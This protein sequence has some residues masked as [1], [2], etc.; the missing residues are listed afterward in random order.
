MSLYI[1]E[2]A[3]RTYAVTTGSG[4]AL[5]AKIAL[6]YE[7][8]SP[9]LRITVKTHK[10]T[11][12]SV[13][14]DL[15]YGPISVKKPN[16][17][18][19]TFAQGGVYTL[20]YDGQAFI[21]QGEG[22]EYGT[23]LA[24]DVLSGKTIGTEDGVI[25]GTIPE[26]ANSRDTYAVWAPWYG[27][28]INVG[29]PIGAYLT[30]GMHGPDK[31]DVMLVEPN[32]IAENIKAGVIM[33]GLEGTAKLENIGFY[34]GSGGKSLYED[35]SMDFGYSGDIDSRMKEPNVVIVKEYD[36]NEIYGVMIKTAPETYQT[37]KNG[38]DIFILDDFPM[39]RVT[40]ESGFKMI[41]VLV[42]YSKE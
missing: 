17:K 37:L 23:A 12:G 7:D 10:A 31:A 18:D 35:D 30:Y 14:I 33:F 32:F 27:G 5:N 36:T 21:L 1:P 6:E 42:V 39:F 3:K 26:W 4:N 41:E 13:T 8:L 34:D 15:G 2:S 9:G 38:V 19:P 29:F 22:G 40:N 20:V 25:E 24:E 11:T 28:R 16:G